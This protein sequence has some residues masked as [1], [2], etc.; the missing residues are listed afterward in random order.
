MLSPGDSAEWIPENVGTFSY[1]D[2]L[3]PWMVG[4]VIVGERSYVTPTPEPT[5]E[6][7]PVYTNTI[8][9]VDE[10]GFSQTCAESQGGAGCYTPLTAV[11]N[12]GD[13]VTMTNTDPTGVHTFT[14]G[15]VNGFTPSPDGTFDSGVLMSG[16]SVEWTANVQVKYHTTVC[17][18]LGWL[19]LL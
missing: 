13:T 4:T 11:V 10:S 17:Y 6:P 9:T 3:H 5:P 8:V 12:Y 2:L 1:F 16:D 18:T 19:E 15:T 14:S 7:T